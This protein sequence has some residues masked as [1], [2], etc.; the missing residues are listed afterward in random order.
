MGCG[1]KFPPQIDPVTGRFV[2]ADQKESVRDSVYLILMTQKTERIQRAEFGSNMMAYVFEDASLTTFHMMARDLENAILSQEPRIA[3]V[4]VRVEET[5]I[6]GHLYLSLQY[7]LFDDTEEEF[8]VPFY[9][10]GLE[11]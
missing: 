5:D 1:M 8:T 11:E 10:N 4:E 9:L 2:E 6:R 3:D 7:T